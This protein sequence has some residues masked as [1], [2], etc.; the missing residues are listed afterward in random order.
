MKIKK[1]KKKNYKNYYLKRFKL[2]SSEPKLP[3]IC[4]ENP[5][6]QTIKEREKERKKKKKNA[7]SVCLCVKFENSNQVLF[8]SYPIRKSLALSFPL[9]SFLS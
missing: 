9:F 2:Q 4:R 1:K 8:S 3:L 7:K 6:D 5:K